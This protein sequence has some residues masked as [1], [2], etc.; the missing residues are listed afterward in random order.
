MDTD[1]L[2]ALLTIVV[3]GAVGGF[4]LAVGSYTAGVAVGL[5]FQGFELVR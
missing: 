3:Y 5:A 4:F 1:D 2:K